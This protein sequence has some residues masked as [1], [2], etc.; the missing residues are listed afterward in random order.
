MDVDHAGV[1]ASQGV[2]LIEGRCVNFVNA[3][4]TFGA[5]LGQ[6][7]QFFEPS[8]A[9]GFDVKSCTGFMKS[10]LNDSVDREFIASAVH[11]EF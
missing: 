11:A 8:S 3:L 9:G 4:D 1:R 5:G 7:D 6:A 2:D 10:A